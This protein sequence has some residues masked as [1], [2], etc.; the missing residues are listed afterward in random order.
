VVSLRALHE[1]GFT[2]R[3]TNDWAV[4]AAGL[5]TNGWLTESDLRAV[6]L[7]RLFGR[8]IGN[9][10]MHF[11]NLTFFLDLELPLKL[12]P[13]YDM[14]P[15]LWAPRVG[16]ATPSP[17]FA[18]PAPMPHELELWPE[19]APLA[20]QFWSRVEGDSQVSENFRAIAAASLRA[21]RTLRERFG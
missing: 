14:L 9:T 21:V 19:V 20:E 7:R 12:A 3:D 16:D 6:R 10:D 2:G 1:A 8:L 13:T 4:A 15:M 5:H 18:P 17:E 11:G